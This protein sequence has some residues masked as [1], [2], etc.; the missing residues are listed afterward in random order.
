MS[1]FPECPEGAA[2]KEEHR[3][4]CDHE[5]EFL[6]E[7]VEAADGEVVGTQSLY[8]QYRRWARNNGYHW[9]G[10]ANFKG[11]V[12]RFFP[13]T[14]TERRRIGVGQNTYFVN[15]KSTRKKRSL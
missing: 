2:L 1:Q 15:I 5:Q 11:A 9:V 14:L 13:G 8:D 12:M 6:I 4:S 7:H 10:S 3:L